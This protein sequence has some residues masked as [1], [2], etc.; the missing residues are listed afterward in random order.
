MTWYIYQ[1]EDLKR[2]QKL[3]FPFYRSLDEGYSPQALIFRDELIQ[4]EA[5]QPAKHPKE[6]VTKTNCVL[7][8][9]L[10]GVD[11]SHFKTKTT[12]K[13]AIYYDVYYNLAV[14]IEAAVM[15]FSLEIDGKEIGS[16]T[17]AYE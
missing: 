8:S 4:C 5:I 1:G 10:T 7:T 14:T 9:D 13:G 3:I 12:A 6:G 2:D 15:R 16:V 17:A 11:V